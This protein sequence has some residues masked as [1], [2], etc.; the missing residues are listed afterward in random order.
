[1]SDIT[2]CPGGACPRKQRCYR[3]RAAAE[4]RQDWFAAVPYDAAQ[5]R[6]DWF[7][8]VSPFEASEDRVRLRAYAKWEEEGRPEGRA[9]AH[10]LAAR[11]ELE[12][13][14]LRP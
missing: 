6:C 1:M 13:E 11:A 10:W 3:Y 12:R 8:D 9:E 7:W 4:G 5:D 2:H 14:L